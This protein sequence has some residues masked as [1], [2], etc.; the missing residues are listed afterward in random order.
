M[1][2]DMVKETYTTPRSYERNQAGLLSFQN[3]D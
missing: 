3:L 1:R 2:E